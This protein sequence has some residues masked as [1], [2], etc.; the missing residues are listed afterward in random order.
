MEDLV[1][2]NMEENAMNHKNTVVEL[3]EEP[4]S[5]MTEERSEPRYPH[6]I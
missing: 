3:E 4:V 5:A 2:R 6:E 1:A